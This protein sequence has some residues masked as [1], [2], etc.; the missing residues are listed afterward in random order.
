MRSRMQ[1]GDPGPGLETVEQGRALQ[2]N[3]GPGQGPSP[4]SVSSL[5]PGA[6]D[7]RTFA[8]AE[9]GTELSAFWKIQ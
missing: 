5:F 9:P 4:S 1:S 7:P 6:L 8:R 2:E 3:L